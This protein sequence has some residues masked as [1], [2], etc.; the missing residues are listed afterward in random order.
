MNFKSIEQKMSQFKIKSYVQKVHDENEVEEI[1]KSLSIDLSGDYKE[2]L[3]KYGECMI[4]EDDLVFPVLEDTPL[5]DEGHLPLGF[6]YGL[7]KN[8][9][10]IR[11][12]RDIYFDQMPEWVLPIADAEGG[13][14]ICIAVKG[15]KKGK[16]YFWDHELRDRQQDLFLIAGSFNDFIQSL[17]VKE[18]PKKDKNNG[19][20][21]IELDED[22]LND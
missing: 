3:L 22:L 10:D 9:Y 15:E 19:I 11:N 13:D 5:T 12:V 16:I 6:F 8:R 14:Q 4:M 7:E 17:F 1:E 18:T 21:S 20:I 2:F